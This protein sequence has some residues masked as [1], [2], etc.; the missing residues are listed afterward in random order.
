MAPSPFDADNFKDLFEFAKHLR[1]VIDHPSGTNLDW[2]L[3][4]QAWQDL[5]SK[6]S[7]QQDLIDQIEWLLGK[8]CQNKLTP[9]RALRDSLDQLQPEPALRLVR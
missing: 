7:C 2:Y 3:I 9:T 6:P 1:A 5:A 8:H 4:R